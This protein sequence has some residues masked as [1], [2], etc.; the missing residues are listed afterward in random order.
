MFWGEGVVAL[1]ISTGFDWAVLGRFTVNVCTLTKNMSNGA[2]RLETEVAWLISARL[3][4][5]V[6]FI[7]VV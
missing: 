2:W 1:C 6:G 4:T 7:L 5:D 3:D